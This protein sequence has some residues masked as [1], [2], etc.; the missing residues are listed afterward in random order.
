MAVF[1]LI[2][3]LVSEVMWRKRRKSGKLFMIGERKRKETLFLLLKKLKQCIEVEEQNQG[4][5]VTIK[6]NAYSE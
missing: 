5:Y 6:L 4:C 3:E 2:W 1:C